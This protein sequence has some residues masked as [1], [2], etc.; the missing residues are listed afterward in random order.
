MSS[1]ALKSS[2][3][4]SIL[5]FSSIDEEEFSFDRSDTFSSTTSEDV[6]VNTV[7]NSVGDGKISVPTPTLNVF[8]A[9]D[10]TLRVPNKSIQVGQ[11]VLCRDDSS[12]AWKRA[13]VKSVNPVRLSAEGA[14]IT[15]SFRDVQPIS[16]ENSNGSPIPEEKNAE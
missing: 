2:L 8:S 10:P 13:I 6:R 15:R 14:N 3:D 5:I 4:L 9:A 1:C 12:D 11:R 7:L 16:F